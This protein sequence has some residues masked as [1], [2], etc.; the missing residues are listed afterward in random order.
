MI[1]FVANRIFIVRN[2]L[3]VCQICQIH[4]ALVLQSHFS[5]CKFLKYHY[6]FEFISGSTSYSQECPTKPQ[7]EAIRSNNFISNGHSIKMQII[8]KNTQRP[9]AVPIN[10]ECTCS[11][12][13][14]LLNLLVIRAAPPA[15]RC[16]KCVQPR[17]VFNSHK[18]G[19]RARRESLLKLLKELHHHNSPFVDVVIYDPVC[20]NNIS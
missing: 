14:P 19:N 8:A 18:Q 1:D 3:H 15:P 9:R 20:Y 17:I 13:P 11:K 10:F 6:F 16:A 5:C 12:F 2:I 4:V 7:F